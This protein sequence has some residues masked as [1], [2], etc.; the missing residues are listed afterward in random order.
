MEETSE[1]VPTIGLEIHAEL[2]T[3][4]KMFCNSKNDPDETRPNVNVCPVCL[5]HPGTLPVV[6]REAVKHVLRVGVAIKGKLA[7]YTEFDRKNYFY[8]DLPKGY[9][10]SQYEFPLIS[11]GELG[12][13][14]IT[15]VHLEEDTAS[16]IHDEATGLRHAEADSG[17]AEAGT[18]TIDYNRSGVPLMELVTE[19]TIHSAEEAGKFA[20][21]LQLLLRHLGASNANME[22]GEMRVEANVSV[23]KKTNNK[24]NILGTKV[25]IKNLNSFRTMERAVAYEIERQRTALENGETIVQETRGWDENKQ[26]TFS[27]RIKEG[28]ADYRYF[29]DPDIPP[30]RLSEIPG[31]G[32]DALR[33]GIGELPSERRARYVSIGVKLDDVDLYVRDMRFGNFFDAVVATY[34]KSQTK[35]I[36]LASN[37]VANDLIKIVRDMEE[38]ETQPIDEIPISSLNFNKII[39]LLINGKISSRSAKDLLLAVISEKKDPEQ[40]AKEKGLFQT[41]DAGALDEVVGKIIADNPGVVADFRAGKAA[42]LEY[43]VGQGM[44]ELRGAAN[45]TILRDLFRKKIG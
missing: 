22:K 7:D 14:A 36:S 23:S 24:N 9:Q 41:E 40:L 17:L 45:P 3:K 16:S 10:I 38:R 25:E 15:R 44:K 34:Q 5:A 33:Q 20:R 39:A 26:S 43:L 37:Y 18:T 28:S 6:N 35:E 8:P 31:L 32:E 30:F 21:E 27:Q 12:G 13:V 4:T 1:Y 11:G 19:P 42:A 2:K 29:P